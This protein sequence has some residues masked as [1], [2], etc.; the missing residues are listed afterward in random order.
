MDIKN[1]RES[2]SDLITPHQSDYGGILHSPKRKRTSSF[3]RMNDGFNKLSPQDVYD[4]TIRKKPCLMVDTSRDCQP[5]CEA[6]S[7]NESF[8]SSITESHDSE[9]VPPSS[10]PPVSTSGLSAY[11]EDIVSDEDPM[12]DDMETTPPPQDSHTPPPPSMHEMECQRPSKEELLTMMEKVDSDISNVEQRIL[13]LEKREEELSETDMSLQTT[14]TPYNV[15]PPVTMV[16]V[17]SHSDTFSRDLTP[18][19]PKGSVIDTIYSENRQKARSNHTVAMGGVFEMLPK[20]YIGV[21]P[22][23]YQPSESPGYWQNIQRHKH[24]RPELLRY[25]KQ[26]KILNHRKELLL[27]T[28]YDDKMNNWERKVEKWE[29]SQ[30]KKNHDIRDKEIFEKVFPELRSK[31]DQLRDQAERFSR[32][33]MRA[34]G[35]VRSEAELNELAYELYAQ[36]EA[37]DRHHRT[38]AVIPSMISDQRE[39]YI[40]YVN[41]NGL[42]RDPMLLYRETKVT[43]TWTDVERSI[44]RDKFALFPK[45]FEKIASF[46]PNKCI[47]DCIRYYYLS[48]KNGNFKS[49]IKRSSFK[50]KR[51]HLPKSHD[52]SLT[53][54]LLMDHSKPKP[55]SLITEQPISTSL[56][57]INSPTSSSQHDIV[58]ESQPIKLKEYNGWT[59]E[60]IVRLKEGLCKFGRAWGKVYREVGGCKTATQCKQFYDDFCTDTKLEL[61][62]A[63]AEHSAKKNAEK[64]RKKMAEMKKNTS[65]TTPL[66]RR[67]KVNK[68]VEEVEH[69]HKGNELSDSSNEGSGSDHGSSKGDRLDTESDSETTIT[70]S[71]PEED[72]PPKPIITPLRFH[73]DSKDNEPLQSPLD[74]FLSAAEALS[75]TVPSEVALHD[76][77]Y[78]RPPMDI[79]GSSGLQLIAAA[80]AV[81]SPSLSKT[82][83]SGNKT[84]LSH[85]VKAPRGRPPSTQKRGS[86]SSQRIGPSFL[87][88]TSGA[89]QNVL[90][91]ELKPTLRGRSRSAPTDKPRPSL[92]PKPLVTPPVLSVRGSPRMSNPLQHPQVSYAR[93]KEIPN[94]ITSGVL[95]SM[96]PPTTVNTTNSLEALVNVA[97]VASPAEIPH[98]IGTSITNTY[99]TQSGLKSSNVPR[100]D[101][102]VLELNLGNMALLLAATGNNQQA[103]LL[104][105]QSSL[106]NKH[107]LA[108]LQGGQV[109]LPEGTA[110]FNIDPS[111]LNQSISSKS[112][113]SIP[114]TQST[115][116]LTTNSDLSKGPVTLVNNN[117]V[118]NNNIASTSNDLIPLVSP[119]NLPRSSKNKEQTLTLS[120]TSD[121]TCSTVSTSPLVTTPSTDDLS[122][123][124]LLSSLVAGMTRK[125]STPIVDSSS[126]LISIP[127]VTQP[128]ATFISSTSQMS[129]HHISNNVQSTNIKHVTTHK[130]MLFH[131]NDDVWRKPNDMRKLDGTLRPVTTSYSTSSQQQSL[132]LYTRSLGMPLNSSAESSPEEEDHLE[133]ATRGIS[134][135]SKLLGNDNGIDSPRDHVRSSLWSPDELLCNPFNSHDHTTGSAKCISSSLTVTSN[136]PSFNHEDTNTV[137]SRT[138]INELSHSSS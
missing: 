116:P 38:H 11:L 69:E 39:K 110:T 114:V 52:Y 87:T 136:V 65:N 47:N 93:N 103:A 138:H 90:L 33:G 8:I 22:L 95:K 26:R 43:S 17:S 53:S 97:A 82:T 135:L 105:P 51:H 88:P 27:C 94:L 70:D 40:K 117:G 21:T 133:Y 102:T 72:T 118:T 50:R 45:N 120:L 35:V 104:L 12:L 127:S 48:K 9:P 32:T 96:T 60:E 4:D 16:T 58:S 71:G 79:Q 37:K 30:K 63:L 124:N 89:S 107:T 73:K 92:P 137:I 84:P 77:T 44:F 62:S 108:V 28:E 34:F 134:E 59:E 29:N 5:L 112:S 78:S 91:Q 55:S 61:N 19:S 85:T 24:F 15:T 129:T 2:N 23:Y 68:L 31:S 64:I 126:S 67:K 123:L 20:R 54:P 75:N 109:C 81:V 74:I 6:L 76:H 57:I 86:T 132:M 115:T 42:L 99:L 80:A 36:E 3:N 125:S 14:G 101:N 119:T 121:K 41:D 106:L 128:V 66:I 18:S 122:N 111:S 98:S 113:N 56:S 100:K 25:L 49:L 131:K 83:W 1:E 130:P 7:S 13:T 46:L 10:C